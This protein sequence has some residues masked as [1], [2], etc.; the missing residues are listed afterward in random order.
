MPIRIA[1]KPII[2]I[3]PNMPTSSFSIIVIWC[4]QSSLFFSFLVSRTPDVI[5]GR[6][7][8]VALK[9]V[10]GSADPAVR[11]GYHRSSQA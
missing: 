8:Q 11:G 2:R 4:L 9:V 5:A 1:G 7:P 6:A 10:T 3:A